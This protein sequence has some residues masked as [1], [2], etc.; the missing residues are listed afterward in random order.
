MRSFPGWGFSGAA[1]QAAQATKDSSCHVLGGPSALQR[2]P[3]HA[4]RG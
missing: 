1:K 3:E 2:H 4:V